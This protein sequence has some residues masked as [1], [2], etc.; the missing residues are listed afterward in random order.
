MILELRRLDLTAERTI[1]ELYLDDTFECYTLEDAAR[2]GPKVPGKTAI[3]AG[4]YAVIVNYS[5]RFQRRLPLLA[6]VPGFTGIR[7][8]AGNTA[9]DT[10]GCILVGQAVEGDVLLRSRA[11]L[12]ALLVKLDAATDCTLTIVNP[13]DVA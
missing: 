2:E 6:G 1:G 12:E 11:A 3:P 5:P 7:I 4:T 8:H 13:P 10:E 9:V